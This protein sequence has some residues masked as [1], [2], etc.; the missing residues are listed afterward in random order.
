MPILAESASV[1]VALNANSTLTISN[2][3]GFATVEFQ[4]R[5]FPT[6]MACL[7][8]RRLRTS[9]EL[10]VTRSMASSALLSSRS[11]ASGKT[12]MSSKDTALFRG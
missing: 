4:D 7:L 2:P 6:T 3:G 8:D 9:V 11:T 5:S 12:Y 10:E 1:D